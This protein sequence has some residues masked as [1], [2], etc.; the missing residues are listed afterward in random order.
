MDTLPEFTC[1]RAGLTTNSTFIGYLCATMSV[2]QQQREG[3][4][5]IDSVLEF[6]YDVEIIVIFKIIL[7]FFLTQILSVPAP[8]PVSRLRSETMQFHP[9][10]EK[11]HETERR[12]GQISGGG[13]C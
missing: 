4:E 10:A 12:L 9:L 5:Y 3:T 6:E 11:V 1:K 7:F 2:H 8:M 13:Q